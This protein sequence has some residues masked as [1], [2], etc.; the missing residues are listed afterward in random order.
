MGQVSHYGTVSHKVSI[1]YLFLD[2]YEVLLTSSCLDA[3][4]V[5][6]RKHSVK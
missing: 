2:C 1:M 4:R 5:I 6:C 3:S